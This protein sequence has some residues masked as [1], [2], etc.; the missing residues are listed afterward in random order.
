MRNKE[1]TMFVSAVDYES[2]AWN[3]GVR[4]SQKVKWI[5]GK[6][7]SALLLDQ[8]INDARPGDKITLT[9]YVN[10]S[11]K[12]TDFILERKKDRPFIIATMGDPEPLQK[13]IFESW[14]KG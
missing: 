12:N 5:N 7:A 6:K 9:L 3:A 14:L 1:D 11:T 2:P 13:Q 4:R 8:T 10:D